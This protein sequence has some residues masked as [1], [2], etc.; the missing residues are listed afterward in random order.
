[1]LHAIVIIHVINEMYAEFMYVVRNNRMQSSDG[2][3]GDI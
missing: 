3:G 2:W 1:M